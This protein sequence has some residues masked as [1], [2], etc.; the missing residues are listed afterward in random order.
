MTPEE[1]RDTFQRFIEAVEAGESIKEACKTAEVAW[2][3]LN[4]W[5]ADTSNV[6]EGGEPYA[7]RY[8]R[9]R[10][11]SAEGFADRA[12]EVAMGARGTAQVERLQVDTLKWRA[13]MANPRAWGDKQQIEVSGGIEHLHLDAL[14]SISAKARIANDLAPAMLR[15]VSPAAQSIDTDQLLD[16]E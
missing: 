2:G 7:T 6:T 13:A 12:L 10:S 4:R 11:L 16:T 8:A 15:D 9:A 3:S 1:R 5:L 14:R